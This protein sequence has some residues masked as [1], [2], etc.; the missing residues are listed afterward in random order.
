MDHAP[1]L[2]LAGR[3]EAIA[4]TDVLQ[5][6]SLGQ[7]DGVLSIEHEDP[8]ERAEIELVS[9]RI[10]N[11]TISGALDRT[12]AALLRRQALDPDQLGEAVR[13]Q[14]SGGSSK[15]IAAVLFEMG[16]VEA[17]ILAEVLTEEIEDRVAQ[18]LSWTVGVFRFRVR[19]QARSIFNGEQF[20]V[21][22]DPQ[23]LLLEAARRW[24]EALR[25][26]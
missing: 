21:A 23:G 6:L 20:G 2:V 7:R 16:A 8:L 24:D 9:G 14:A 19:Q 3:L 25:E 10:V 13:R 22:L 17:G 26:H 4:L 11:A 5:L 15:P 18:I 1:S 12:A